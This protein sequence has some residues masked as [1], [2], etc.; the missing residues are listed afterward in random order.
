MFEKTNQF[1]N[2]NV[3]TDI[4]NWNAYEDH[5]KEDHIKD[6][7]KEV[8]INTINQYEIL[9]GVITKIL[10]KEIIVDIHFKYEGIISI[11]EF[12]NKKNIKVGDTIDVMVEKIYKGQLL[13]S[14]RK[15]KIRR[16]WERAKEA[17]KNREIITGKVIGRTKGGMIVRILEH[18]EAFM[19]GSQIDPKPLYNFDNFYSEVYNKYME[20][21]I[22]KINNEYKNIVV[23]H[24]ALIEDEIEKQKKKFISELQP[25]QI[26]IAK[27][28]NI[29][30]YGAFCDLGGIDGLVHNSDI[31]WKRINHPSDVLKINEK[32]KV[33]ILDF[34][35]DKNR[36]QLGIK[37]LLPNPWISLDKNLKIGNKIK[38]KVIAIT[39]YGA[40]VE[41]ENHPGVEALLHVSEISWSNQLRLAKDFIKIDDVVE[42]VILTLDRKE[43]KMSLGVKELTKNPWLEIQEKYKKGSIHTGTIR[44]VTEYG[45]FV[46]L[47]EGIDGMIHNSDLSYTNF[48]LGVGDIIETI[49]LEMDVEHQR[50]H[51][52]L[53]I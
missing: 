28:K 53:R 7:Y 34:N 41:I 44:H 31:S 19:P 46:E 40:F 24:K 13:L 12:R 38:G 33:V 10:D 9:R 21:K 6:F 29:T 51:L 1:I 4:F 36:I 18:I 8:S 23:S 30:S 47:E 15:A 16:S 26:I 50:I 39:E 17:Y 25:G 20:F 32:V 27:V 45:V 35:E 3:S 42:G 5:Q 52:G 43:K 11:N 2:A 49:V 22:L 37:H 14:N 48:K